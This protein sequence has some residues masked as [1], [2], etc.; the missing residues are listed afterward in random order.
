MLKRK[1]CARNK[2]NNSRETN[3]ES[4]LLYS[5]FWDALD[6]SQE[7]FFIDE[8]YLNNTPVDTKKMLKALM[9]RVQFIQIYLRW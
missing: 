1:K 8:K 5:A 3:V 6:L 7:S 2:G 4:V 9:K